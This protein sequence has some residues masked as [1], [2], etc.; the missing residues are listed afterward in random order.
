[1]NSL[2]HLALYLNLLD[3]EAVVT[4][5]SQY[6]FL[7]D[8]AHTLGEV[9]PHWR[10]KGVRSYTWKV[11]PH[12]PDP[13]AG[14]L[15]SYRPFPR[16][17]VQ[18][19]WTHEYAAAW[20]YLSENAAAAGEPPFPTPEQMLARTYEGNI[21]FEGDV[22]AD[23]EGSD[24]IKRAI[25]DDD[26]RTLWLLSWGGMNTI[27]RALISIAEE[28]R[29]APDWEAV[30]ARVCA[31]ARVMG[32]AQGVGQDNSWLDHGR[33]LF[34]DLVFLRAPFAYGGY[35]D[36]VTAQPDSIELFRAP[37]PEQH[38]TRGNGSLMARYMLYGDGKVYEN[39]PE[40][41]Q[42]GKTAT[43]DWGL[44]GMDPI[45][46]TPGD[47]MAEGDSMTYIPL[48]PFGLRGAAEHGFDTVLGPLFP[49]AVP[50]SRSADGA[51]PCTSAPDGSSQASVT[52]DDGFDFSSLGKPAAAGENP[53]PYLRAYQEDFAVRAAWCAH[54]PEACNHAPLVNGVSADATV[55]PGE[56]AEVSALVSDPDGDAVRCRWFV[57]ALVSSYHGA[58]DLSAWEAVTVLPGD[59]DAATPPAGASAASAASVTAAFPVPADA[60]SGDRIILTLAA[61]D[62]AALPATRYAQV[63]LTVA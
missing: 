46:F 59:G 40:R 15:K 55:R 10:T 20:P 56:V 23:T 48:I 35:V 24:V 38:L 30:R 51:A 33:A 63:A 45:R 16:T 36:A 50:D 19:L 14:A 58:G 18:D 42:F 22:R 3:V 43:L 13:E 4:T 34:P 11:V 31:K 41:F 6:H 27:V 9:T 5:A 21:A 29:D 8:G 49:D 12:E 62:E 32:V 25:L 53:N 17:W 47:F 39:E 1:M 61:R 60:R 37:W 7:G 57:D 2:I 28:H 52:P 54:G 26:P 44:D